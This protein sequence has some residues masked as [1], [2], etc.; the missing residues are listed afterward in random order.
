VVA[1]IQAKAERA[2]DQLAAALVGDDVLAIDQERWQA[3]AHSPR[4][5]GG[6]SAPR[7]SASIRYP[8]EAT[9]ELASCLRRS[10]RRDALAVAL[11][12]IKARRWGRNL[13]RLA[14]VAARW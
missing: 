1:A 8:L 2:A 9:A 5:T 7:R 10:P 13:T 11:L 14:P 3:M 4:P 6:R 12:R